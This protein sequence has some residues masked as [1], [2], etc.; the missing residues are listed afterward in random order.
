VGVACT[1]G[2]HAENSDVLL[3]GSVA[4]AVTTWPDWTFTGRL[5]FIGALQL[6]S[7]MMLVEPMKVC[8]WPKPEEW[9]W[10]LSKNSTRNVVF[11]V[12]SKLP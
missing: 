10:A 9:H 2:L 3:F 12:L 4:V 1:A 11:A 8:P 6:P 7:V 5:T